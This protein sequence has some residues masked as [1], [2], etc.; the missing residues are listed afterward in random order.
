MFFLPIP[1]TLPGLSFLDLVLEGVYIV[2][3]SCCVCDLTVNRM[4]LVH[5]RVFM[6]PLSCEIV[7]SVPGIAHQFRPAWL[8]RCNVP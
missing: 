4:G 7:W 2:M 8:I 5:V 6:S 3:I 1:P